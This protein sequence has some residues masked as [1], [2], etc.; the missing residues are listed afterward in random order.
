M[1]LR[2]SKYRNNFTF[3]PLRFLTSSKHEIPK[4]MVATITLVMWKMYKFGVFLRMESCDLLLSWRRKKWL[5]VNLVSTALWTW[6]LHNN[7]RDSTEE[8]V[9]ST[10][11]NASERRF[12]EHIST[13]FPA[14][15]PVSARR[16]QASSADSSGRGMGSRVARTGC[17]IVQL[18]A[19]CIPW[20]QAQRKEAS[21]EEVNVWMIYMSQ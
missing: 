16:E 19:R 9:D 17:A 18:I 21:C 5:C 3:W 15:P 20:V 14:R 11:Q 4:W 10:Q 13:G 7:V 8:Y 6:V 2:I 12:I 1:A